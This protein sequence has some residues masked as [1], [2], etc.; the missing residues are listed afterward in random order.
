MEDFAGCNFAG[1]EGAVELNAK[2]C[3]EFVVIGESAPDAG[4]GGL[5]FDGFLDAISGLIL[6]AG[7]GGHMQPPGCI[8]RRKVG[9]GEQHSGI[10]NRAELHL[11]GSLLSL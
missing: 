10:G 2:P 6:G 1:P 3:A 11:P 9:N 7:S 5:Q 8:L 4:D